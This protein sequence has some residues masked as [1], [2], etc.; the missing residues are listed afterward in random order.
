MQECCPCVCLS[1]RLLPK[2][3]TKLEGSAFTSDKGL[4]MAQWIKP[5][6]NH[7]SLALWLPWDFPDIKFRVQSYVA[8]TIAEKA[9]RFRHR[10]YDPDEAQKLIS[11]SMCRHL[12]TRNTSSKSIH[13]FLS[14]LANRQTDRHGQ[15]TCTSSFVRG[16][17]AVF[18]KT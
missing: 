13:A 1:I 8:Y 12:S 7:R 14:N 5:F 9:I 18:S 10:D 15:K 3:H 6:W 16:K 11:S 4:L 2:T 17:N